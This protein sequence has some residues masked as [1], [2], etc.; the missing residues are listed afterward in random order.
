M[1]AYGVGKAALEAL[2]SALAQEV[3]GTGVTVNVVRVRA[4]DTA[5]GESGSEK[6]YA[7]SP[8]EISAAIRYLFSDRA[9]VV[10]GERIGLHGGV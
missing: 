1:G 6:P 4:I 3:A 10:N 8:A 7:T 9:R 5:A 2:F